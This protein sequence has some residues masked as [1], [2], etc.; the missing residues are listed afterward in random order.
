MKH[1]LKTQLAVWM[2]A[3]VAMPLSA[4]HS[5]SA[6]YDVDKPISLH[7]TLTKIEWINPHGWIYVNV[8]RD[9]G[10]VTGWAVE[11]GSPN[12]LL[13]RGVRKTDFPVGVELLIKGYRAKNGSSTINGTSVKVPDG[14]N[15]YTGSSGD[16]APDPQCCAYSFGYFPR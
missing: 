3:A 14:H 11:F 6:E 1:Y 2:M 12:A 4:H 7:G 16:G 10:K 15:F 13:R 8:K 9:D 5:F